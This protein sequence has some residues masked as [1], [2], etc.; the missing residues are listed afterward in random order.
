MTATHSA[1]HSAA[2]TAEATTTR[3]PL[4]TLS[5]DEITAAAAVVGSA[6]LVGETTRF[7]Y[8]GLLEAPKAAV[9]AWE[10][11]TGAP[12]PRQVRVQLLDLATGA[13]HDTVADVT[14][15]SLVSQEVLD[16]AEVGQLPILDLEFE[17]VPEIVAASAEWTGAL[18]KRGLDPATVVTVPLSAGAFGYEDEAG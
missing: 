18:A 15:G 5:A 6:G 9:L 17:I 4:A 1:T 16:T 10:A 7:V 12:P 8:V 3:H 11:G 2:P 13:Q 14:A